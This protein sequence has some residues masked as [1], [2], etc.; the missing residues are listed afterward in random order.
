LTVTNEDN[1]L[2]FVFDTASGNLRSWRTRSTKGETTELR[3]SELELNNTIPEQAF[4][5]VAPANARQVP[6]EENTRKFQF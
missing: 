4:E 5:W 3:W 2:E 6:P 1:S